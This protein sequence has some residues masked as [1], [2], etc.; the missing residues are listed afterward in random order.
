MAGCFSQH[1]A[2]DRTETSKH[3]AANVIEALR[4]CKSGA[5]VASVARKFGV[6]GATLHAWQK[7]YATLDASSLRRV[8]QHEAEN[9]KLKNLVVVLSLDNVLLHD[10]LEQKG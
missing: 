4:Q 8:R 1:P 9:S 5:P 3:S 7:K 2:R 6:S 10:R